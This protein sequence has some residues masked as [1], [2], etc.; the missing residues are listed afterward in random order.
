MGVMARYW[1]GQ[2]SDTGLHNISARACVFVSICL[3]ACVRA[4]VCVCMCVCVCVCARARARARTCVHMLKHTGKL[5]LHNVG[6]SH[7]DCMPG[8][9]ALYVL[10]VPP[11]AYL[12]DQ[13]K[14]C[15]PGYLPQPRTLAAHCVH[16]TLSERSEGH[17]TDMGRHQVR[18]QVHA[19][20]PPYL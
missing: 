20:Q 18:V 14:S 16:S 7:A 15:Y 6:G 11:P 2:G 4:C 9:E 19:L 5:T 10:T 17:G 12:T 13:G 3:H 8:F 1:I